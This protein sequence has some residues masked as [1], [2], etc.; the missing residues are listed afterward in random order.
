MAYRLADGESAEVALKRCA[1]EQLDRAIAEL[2]DGVKTDPVRAVHET[3][4]ALKKERSLLLR[5]LE[6]IS[7]GTMHGHAQEAHRLSD[8]LGDDHDLAVLRASLVASGAALPVDLDSVI[9]LIDHRREQLQAEA[10]LVGTR[11]YAEKPKAFR[12]RIHRYWKAWRADRTLRRLVA[13]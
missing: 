4:K 10:T 2:T 11:L 9:M 1:G 13:R 5:L 12:R 8:L 7:P 6:P 3:R